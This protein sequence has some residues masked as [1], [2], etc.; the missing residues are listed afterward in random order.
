MAREGLRAHLPAGGIQV[1]TI[2]GMGE[3]AEPGVGPTEARD[4][5]NDTGVPEWK[6]PPPLPP[7]PD[8]Q[9]LQ[10]EVDALRA[11]NEELK[12]RLGER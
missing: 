8:A 12:K 9:C 3:P 5:T 6:P 1:V 10:G 11:E 7:V 2:K 4:W